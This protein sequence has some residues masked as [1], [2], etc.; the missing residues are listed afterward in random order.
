MKIYGD[1]ISPFVRGCLVCGHEAGL[2][3][4]VQWVAI[5]VK[6]TEEQAD[7]VKLSPIGKIP[8]LE[9]DHHHPIYDSRVIMEYLCHVAGNST[10]I[11]DDG[12]KRFRVLTL[13]ALAAGMADA[14]VALRYEQAQRPEGTQ[15]QELMERH[16]QRLRAGIHDIEQHWKQDLQTVSVATIM[17]ATALSY[18]DFRHGDLQWRELSAVV[19]NFHED[20]C[21]RA[22]MK[23]FA[24]PA[25]K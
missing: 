23:A 17:L 22:S 24:L 18:L 1:V 25:L 5:N 21:N 14:A 11:P 20:F 4:R 6:P 10:L 7:L 15:W 13:Q 8:V 16:R 2:G 19:A 12:V 9:T 3:A